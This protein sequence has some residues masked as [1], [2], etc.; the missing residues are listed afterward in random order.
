MTPGL[1]G[2]LAPGRDEAAWEQSIADVLAALAGEFEVVPERG[3]EPVG[4]DRRTLLDTFDWRLYRARLSL[5]YIARSVG[6][7]LR[8]AVDGPAAQPAAAQP[9]VT[10]TVVAQ[11]VTGWQ[12][13]RPHLM[14]EVPDGPVAS[15]I[16]DL[17]APRALLPVVTVSTAQTTYR[18]LNEDGKTVARLLVERSAIGGQRSGPPATGLAPRLSIDR[19]SV[20]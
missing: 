10:Q 14:C 18:L 8:L 11:P 16:G 12:A 7:E 2:F 5:E 19:K 3:G 1:A 15:R 13:A 17:V 20:V 9:V 6:G 4:A